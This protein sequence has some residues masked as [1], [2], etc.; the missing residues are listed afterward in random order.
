[1]NPTDF[2]FVFI[3]NTNVCIQGKKRVMRSENI[4]KETISIDH[5]RLVNF[6]LGGRKMGDDPVIAGSIPEMDDTLY[7]YLKGIGF[8]ANKF[9]QNLEGQEKEVDAEICASIGDVMERY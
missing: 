5:G 1:M 6:V 7:E 8:K 4:L 3:D 2:V 9:D